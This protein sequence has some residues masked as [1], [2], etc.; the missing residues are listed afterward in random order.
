M[1]IAH[2]I[3]DTKVIFKAKKAVLLFATDFSPLFSFCAV[4]LGRGVTVPHVPCFDRP[5]VCWDSPC[6]GPRRS[7]N[8][9]VRIFILFSVLVS[10]TS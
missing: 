7:R 1:Q 10:A 2:K 8:G 6:A 9:Y 5:V 3:T 4:K